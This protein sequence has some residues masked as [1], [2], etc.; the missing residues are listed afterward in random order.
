[1]GWADHHRITGN[2]TQ[3]IVASA[4]RTRLQM[5]SQNC[6]KTRH[7]LFKGQMPQR[8][9][10]NCT[11][12]WVKN[13]F[14]AT[15]GRGRVQRWICTACQLDRNDFDQAVSTKILQAF[16]LL[17]RRLPLDQAEYLVGVKSETIRQELMLVHANP[18]CWASIQKMLLELEVEAPEIEYLNSVV[19]IMSLTKR[20]SPGVGRHLRENVARLKTKIESVIGAEVV[21]ARARQGVRVC[22]KE[23]FDDF[24]RE[25]RM[26]PIETL[27]SAGLTQLQWKVLEQLRLPV[28]K[29]QLLSSVFS[30]EAKEIDPVTM[31]P[32]PP[33]VTLKSL[34][35]GLNMDFERFKGIV[36]ALVRKLQC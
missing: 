33:K 14:Y 36:I 4:S 3:L 1:M 12:R 13:G 22:R 7:R 5:R 15:I 17:A 10:E 9:Q 27:K 6:G 20:C 25:V 2:L 32:L 19:T 24:I 16:A 23:H 34:A 30:R 28:K 8:E 21:I 18:E 31:K 29:A 35:D 11:H 26:L